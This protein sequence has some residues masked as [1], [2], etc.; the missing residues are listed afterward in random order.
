MAEILEWESVGLSVDTLIGEWTVDQV[1]S[2]AAMRG[3]IKSIERLR[4]GGE[5]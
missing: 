1:R 4:E 3:T 5:S 2:F